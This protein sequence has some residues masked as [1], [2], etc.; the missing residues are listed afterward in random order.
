M[1]GWRQRLEAIILTAWYEGSPW[2][3]CLWPLSILVRGVAWRRRAGLTRALPLR[4]PVIIVGGVTVGGTGKT[5]VVIALVESLRARGFTIGVVSR[6]YSSSVGEGPLRVEARSTASAV[7]DEP[8]LIALRTQVPVVVGRNRWQAAKRLLDTTDVNV[9]ISDDG[10]QHYAL[11]RDFEIAVLDAHRGLGN[12][13]VLPMG[14]LR[15]PPERLSTV[16]WVLE[17]N[18]TDPDTGFHYQ[19]HHLLHWQ[20]RRVMEFSPAKAEW[21]TMQLAA[22]TALGQPEQFFAGL[23]SLE[24]DFER[25]SFPDHHPLSKQDLDAIAADIIIITEKDAVKIDAFDDPRI[26]VLVISAKLPEA[27]IEFLAQ[28]LNDEGESRC[29]T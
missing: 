28:G 5:P 4:A 13:R 19:Q 22:V 17:R 24:L 11:P 23:A 8:L 21:Q 26:W 20:T 25:Y 18:G 3:W 7:G 12:G 14:P 15:E 1:S 10:L 27:L 2:L 16:D 6:G 29:T 9:V